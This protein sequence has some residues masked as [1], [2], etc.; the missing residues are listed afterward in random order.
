M[1]KFSVPVSDVVK[2][3]IPQASISHFRL[4]DSPAD[5]LARVA[6]LRPDNRYLKSHGHK[7]YT[8]NGD[9]T[10][11]GAIQHATHGDLSAVAAAEKL[12]AAIDEM[13]PAPTTRHVMVDDVAGG[14]ANVQAYLAG[15]PLAMRRKAKREDEFAPLA[16]IVDLASQANVTADQLRTRGV[17]IL[18]LCRALSARRPVELWAGVSQGIDH[19]SRNSQAVHSYVK[20]ETAPM[21]LA[22]AAFILSHPAMPRQILYAL[23]NDDFAEIPEGG[24]FAFGAATQA[25][26]HFREI[27]GQGFPEVSE[28]L[29]V[30][31]AMGADHIITDPIPW[32]AQHVHAYGGGE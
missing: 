23:G 7:A 11:A 30:P 5:L 3:A 9:T 22:R 6:R 29:T 13:L 12:L 25:R 2:A 28:V 19:N 16:I 15:H 31:V 17:G 10:L 20:I 14:A 1:R 26:T 18:A 32:I 21:D 4:Y 27:I 8:W 24:P